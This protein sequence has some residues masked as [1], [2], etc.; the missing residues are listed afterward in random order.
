MTAEPALHIARDNTG[1][2]VHGRASIEVNP[3]LAHDTEALIAEARALWW[4]VDR[5]NLFIKIPAARLGLPAITACLAEG[6]SVNVTLIFSLT[7]HDEVIEAFLHGLKRARD[8]GRDLSSIASVASFFVSR[9][10]TEADARRVLARLHALGVDYD[11][12]TAVLEERGLEM[13][14]ASWRELS[15]QLATALRCPRENHRAQEES[16]I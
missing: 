16:G 14:D 10:D 2:G 12:V 9:V 8:A 11:D 13:F 3:R 7:R 1:G 6:I 4:Q 5:P 15:D